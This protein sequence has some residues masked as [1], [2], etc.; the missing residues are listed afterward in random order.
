ML[1]DL[2]T[3]L[4]GLPTLPPLEFPS[5]PLDSLTIGPDDFDPV[6]WALG[7]A[8]QAIGWTWDSIG[9]PVINSVASVGRAMIDNPGATALT[10]GRLAL[11]GLGATGEGIGIALLPTGL[12]TAGGGTAAGAGVMIGSTELIVAG[13][14]MATAGGMIL[15]NEAAQNPQEVV[16]GSE[17]QTYRPSSGGGEPP[18]PAR[19]VTGELPAG[20]SPGV[21]TVE[22]DSQLQSTYDQMA[23][24]GEVISRPGYK[25]EW[26]RQPD[27][28]EIGLREGSKSG[29]RTIDIRYPDG[30]T[31]KVHIS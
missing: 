15:L 19:D 9:V 13:G 20:K 2:G 14:A 21:K 25:G 3:L 8:K 11:M 4:P 31:Q 29:G 28:T 10:L 24:G 23:R 5:A 7:T 22:T 12:V 17:P 16:H 18:R 6:D 27:G 30:S 1:F 26:V